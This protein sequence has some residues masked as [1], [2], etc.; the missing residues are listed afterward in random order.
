MQYTVTSD[1]A[2]PLLWLNSLLFNMVKGKVQNRGAPAKKPPTLP[3]SASKKS[4]TSVSSPAACATA[5][6]KSVVGGPVPSCGGCGTVITEDVKS[7]QCD[8]CQGDQW[9]CV[10]CLNITAE[11]YDQLVSDPLCSL[12]WFCDGCDKVVSCLDANSITAAVMNSVSN[13]MDQFAEVMRN[14][15]R[16]LIARMV[17]VEQKLQQKADMEDVKD[18][19]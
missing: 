17:V 10:D 18:T 11:V 1:E 8:R 3:A 15:E 13:T 12:K 14:M 7:L 9:K 6:R 19:V 2:T 4:T 16:N 5:A